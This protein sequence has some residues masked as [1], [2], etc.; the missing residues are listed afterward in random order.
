MRAMTARAASGWRSGRSASGRRGIA[1][2]SAA[3]AGSSALG[4]TPNQAIDP[5]RTP[6]RLPPNGARVS[7]MSSTP[8]RP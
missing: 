8:A 2:S 4:G 1:T 3:W 6:S 5:A 7:Q